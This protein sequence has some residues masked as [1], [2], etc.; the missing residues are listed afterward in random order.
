MQ[1]RNVVTAMHQDVT[2]QLVELIEGLYF[3]IEDGL[4]ELAF[5]EDTEEARSRCF[6]LMREMRLRKHQLVQIF[7]NKL[8]KY[9]RVWFG[10]PNLEEISVEAEL[11]SARAAEQVSDHFQVLLGMISERVNLAI[12]SELD[13]NEMPISPRM[14]A[15]AFISTCLA[16][17]FD[18]AAVDL[19]QD[20]FRRFVLER[21]GGIYA[22]CNE[23]LEAAG[24]QT[25]SELDFASTA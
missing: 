9:Q 8:T 20:L 24:C 22:Q 13:P 7:A 16:L 25:A 14:V 19:V 21:L 2:A 6:D 10:N 12:G 3:N 15:R 23:R 1:P 4:F 5:R 11:L 17:R 18:G